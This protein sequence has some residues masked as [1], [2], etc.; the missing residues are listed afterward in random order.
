MNWP[1]EASCFLGERRDP[2]KPDIPHR[3]PE[4]EIRARRSLIPVVRP[5]SNASRKSY[6]KPRTGQWRTA[7]LLLS[8]ARAYSLSAVV[9]SFM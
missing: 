9:S 5:S 2:P 7:A 6:L 3:A 4:S 1:L 8:L